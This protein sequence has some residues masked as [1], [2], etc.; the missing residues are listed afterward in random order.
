VAWGTTGDEDGRARGKTTSS[1][2]AAQGSA[3]ERSIEAGCIA[4]SMVIA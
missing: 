4:V 3:L 1:L 2:V